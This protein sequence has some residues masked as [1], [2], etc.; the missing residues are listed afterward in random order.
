MQLQKGALSTAETCV[1]SLNVAVGNLAV[2]KCRHYILEMSQNYVC[3]RQLH[4]F[5]GGGVAH[6]TALRLIFC[7]LHGH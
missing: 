6:G 2:V 5:R 3:F 7:A 1:A 4:C